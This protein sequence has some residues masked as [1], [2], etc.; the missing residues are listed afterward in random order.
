MERFGRYRLTPM[1]DNAT[2][3][4]LRGKAFVNIEPQLRSANR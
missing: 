2:T 4:E 1:V 3:R